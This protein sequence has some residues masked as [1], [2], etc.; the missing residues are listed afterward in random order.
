MSWLATSWTEDNCRLDNIRGDMAILLEP[1][2]IGADL[3]DFYVRNRIGMKSIVIRTEEKTIYG[4]RNVKDITNALSAFAKQKWR[5]SPDVG[6][7]LLHLHDSDQAGVPGRLTG[8]DFEHVCAAIIR[9]AGL[10]VEVTSASGDKGVDLLAETPDY[11]VAI[12][13]KLLSKP[14]GLKAVQEVVAG[15]KHYAT[16]YGMV[17]CDAGFT[18]AAE[19][20]AQSNGVILG[21]QRMLR[22]LSDVF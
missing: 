14:A 4:Q 18:K 7:V 1:F 12:Q 15:M 11:R 10:S 5:K 20:L 6:A 17:V 19:D 9:E 13:C 3:T 2:T 21:D 8:G 16:D 22:R